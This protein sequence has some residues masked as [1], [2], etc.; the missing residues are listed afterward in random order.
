MSY[1]LFAFFVL[2]FVCCS[3]SLASCIVMILHI[4]MHT[5]SHNRTERQTALVAFACWLIKSNL[6]RNVFDI[7]YT[8]KSLLTHRVKWAG[9]H[10]SC[11]AEKKKKTT[12]WK[13]SKS[14]SHWVIPNGE[15]TMKHTYTQYNR[16]TQV[17]VFSELMAVSHLNFLWFFAAFNVI[18][19]P[20][21]DAFSNCAF[22]VHMQTAP[23][24]MSIQNFFCFHFVANFRMSGLWW[25][26]LHCVAIVWVW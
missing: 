21:S 3:V 4:A 16:C 14:T 5:N 1:I 6:I 22:L 2:C 17:Q 12:T 26:T 15:Y 19:S 13:C 23:I 8:R 11:Q 7:I 20:R 25:H 9:L 18:A 24:W 10:I